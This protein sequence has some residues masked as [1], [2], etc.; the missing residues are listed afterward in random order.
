MPDNPIAMAGVGAPGTVSGNGVGAAA[1]LGNVPGGGGAPQTGN[2]GALG[3][4]E[5]LRAALQ[6]LSG[7]LGRPN[8][9]VTRDSDGVPLWIDLLGATEGGV[10]IPGHTLGLQFGEPPQGASTNPVTFFAQGIATFA[11]LGVPI[12]VWIAGAGAFLFFVLPRLRGG[13]R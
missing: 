7:V 8:L 2:L 6:S 9:V 11:P 3:Q 4:I 12:W 5:Q 10:T 13:K 1:P